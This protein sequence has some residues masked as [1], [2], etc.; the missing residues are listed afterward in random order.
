MTAHQAAHHFGFP[1]RAESGT[2]FFRLFDRDQLIDDFAALDQELVH[3]GVDAIDLA[4]QIGKR[5]RGFARRFTGR[6]THL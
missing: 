6:F 4:P 1:R 5:R 3:G 2:G